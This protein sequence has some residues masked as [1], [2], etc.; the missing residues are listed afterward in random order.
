[1]LLRSW[2][3]GIS[4]PQRRIGNGELVEGVDD[5]AQPLNDALVQLVWMGITI[6]CDRLVSS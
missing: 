5:I 6:Y 2:A 3:T 4:Q 1:M